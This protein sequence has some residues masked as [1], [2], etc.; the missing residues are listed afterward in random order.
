MSLFVPKICVIVRVEKCRETIVG[1]SRLFV[2]H[3][4]NKILLQSDTICDTIYTRKE[5]MVFEC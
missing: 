3:R 4:L 5:R 1:S 2:Y